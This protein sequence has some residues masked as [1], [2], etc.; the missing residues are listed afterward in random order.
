MTYKSHI[1]LVTERIKE[2]SDGQDATIH[3]ISEI[4]NSDFTDE[5]KIELIAAESTAFLKWK[6]LRME[7]VVPSSG[8][9]TVESWENQLQ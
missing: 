9:V 6:G 8:F 3:F 1:P 7:R 5:A 2:V 4:L